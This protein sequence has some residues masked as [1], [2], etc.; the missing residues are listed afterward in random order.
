MRRSVEAQARLRKLEAES[1]RGREQPGFGSAERRQPEAGTLPRAATRSIGPSSAPGA[2]APITRSAV[3]SAVPTPAPAP[4]A[5]QQKFHVVP[6][7][8]GTDRNQVKQ[9]GRIGYANDRAKRL[10]LGRALISV[11]L[12]HK[13]PNIERP[14]AWEI[15]YFGTIQLEKEDPARHFTVREIRTLTK[16]EMLA[17]VKTRLGSSRSFANQSIVFIHGYNTGFDSALYRTAQISFDLQFDGAAFAYS[18]PAGGGLS[19]YNYDRDSAEQAE[20]FLYEFLQ[21][22]QNE[23][24][25]AG[26]NIIAHSMGNQML[27]RVL[28][29]L[30]LRAPAATSRINQIILA[31]P[32]V[33]REVFESIANE[34]TGV[35]RGITL[36]AAAN[37]LALEASRFVAAGRPRAGDVP[38]D[39]PVIV[40]GIDT[41]DITN[42]STAYLALNHSGYAESSELLTDIAQI[43]RTGTRPWSRRLKAYRPVTLPAGTYWRYVN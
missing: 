38:P 9:Q 3:P 23:T 1:S 16:A 19:R 32:D 13:V 24:G 20:R 33:D 4:L 42:V 11:P 36:Y 18:W 30:K 29:T 34:I 31:S 41:I 39:G 7:F 12:D 35:A 25:S 15:P 2:S 26:I 22:V 28:R 27:L 10:E 17:L 40:K 6:V 37:D 5:S 8:Y 21:M 14:R 43:F